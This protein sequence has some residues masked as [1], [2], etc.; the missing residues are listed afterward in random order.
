MTPY[1][2]MVVIGTAACFTIWLFT[3]DDTAF[4]G[5]FFGLGYLAGYLA[6]LYDDW[7]AGLE[8]DK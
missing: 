1:W 4:T 2:F 3:D 7:I 5:G 6:R 8:R